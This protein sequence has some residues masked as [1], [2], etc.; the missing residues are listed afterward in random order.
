MTT[1]DAQPRGDEL[2][3]LWRALRRDLANAVLEMSG[4]REGTVAVDRFEKNW[5]K[6][7]DLD[8]DIAANLYHGIDQIHMLAGRLGKPNSPA[9]HALRKLKEIVGLAGIGREQNPNAEVR[10]VGELVALG[11]QAVRDEVDSETE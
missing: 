5:V 9:D 4:F 2:E 7:C 8:L 6:L 1:S 3:R 10:T 11:E